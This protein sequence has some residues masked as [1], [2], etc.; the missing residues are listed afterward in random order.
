MCG[1]VGMFKKASLVE[2]ERTLVAN[3][4]R[5]IAHRGP[6]EDKA[7]EFEN[8]AIAFRRLSIIDLEKGSQPFEYGDRYVGIFNG[9][10]YNYRDLREDLIKQ[11]YTFNTNSEI[12]VMLT[13]FSI[14]G[15]AFINKLRGMFAFCFYDK[16]KNTV[17]LGR[18]P[19]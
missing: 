8:L 1:F 9:E 14:E 17:T 12:E 6:D 10:I 2:E 16:E 15:E 11:G 3:M 7:L 4:S 13:L 18:D 5:A 19:F